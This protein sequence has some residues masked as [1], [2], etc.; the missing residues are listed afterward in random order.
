MA[1]SLSA[2]ELHSVHSGE[3]TMALLHC[4][5]CAV[6]PGCVNRAAA[7]LLLPS[8]KTVSAPPLTRVW[9]A[10]NNTHRPG[11]SDR[12]T[13]LENKPG[14]QFACDVIKERRQ[15]EEVQSGS[16]VMQRLKVAL[17]VRGRIYSSFHAFPGLRGQ[18]ESSALVNPLE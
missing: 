10:V 1:A 12:S 7:C 6:V 5:T 2:A 4:G 16:S 13:R 9:S 17:S 8:C 15:P 18:Q 3:H 14:T 11:L